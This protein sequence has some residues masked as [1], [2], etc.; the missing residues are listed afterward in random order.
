MKILFLGTNGWYDSET[1]NTVCVLVET[2]KEY[3]IFDAGNGFYKLDRYIICNKPVYLFLSHYHLD[4]V[5][6]L[7][8]LNK[9]H[10]KQGIDI[11]GPLGLRMLFKK[12]INKPYTIPLSDLPMRLRLHEISKGTILPSGISYALL[13]HSALCYGYR[14]CSE[15]KTIAYCTDTGICDNLFYLARN[16]DLLITECSYKRG[17]KSDTWPHLN[18]ESSARIA[19]KAKVRKLM[20]LHFDASI[21]P[22]FKERALAEAYA[23]KIFKNSKAA[24]DGAVEIV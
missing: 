16:A 18:P 11:Y 7:H 8:M 9:F 22:T 24:R 3:I 21:Y 4:H 2:K 23:K 19:K 10:F 15:D 20:L 6:G 13:K 14:F 1:G 5:I 17:Q 12:V